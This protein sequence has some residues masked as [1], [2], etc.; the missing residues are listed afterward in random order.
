L[1]PF[2]GRSEYLCTLLDDPRLLGIT[3]SLVGEDFN[4]LTS[5]GSYYVG[6]TGW[7]SDGWRSEFRHLNLAFYLDELTR[8]T[9]CLRV[10]PGSHR[11]GDAFADA[12]QDQ[13]G[14]CE[15]TWGIDGHEVPSMPLEVHPGDLV[16]FNKNLKHS[17]WGAAAAVACSR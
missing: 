12:L 14:R 16:C 6:N 11:P 4:Y 17:S 7:H 1:V 8:D 9:G 15:G 2:V 5:D 10:I 13:A 3:V